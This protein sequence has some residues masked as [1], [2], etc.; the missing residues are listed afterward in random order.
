MSLYAVGHNPYRSG[1]GDGPP[2]SEIVW[3]FMAQF[4]KT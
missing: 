3:E 2:S 4:T 1:T